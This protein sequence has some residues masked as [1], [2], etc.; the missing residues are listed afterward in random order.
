MIYK[1]AKVLSISL[2]FLSVQNLFS[3]TKIV[4]GTEAVKREFPFIVS[5]QKSSW[6]SYSHICGA[7]LV[8]PGWVLTAAHCVYRASA[9]SFRLK[10]GLH[11]QS[12]TTGVETIKA[13]KIIVHSS[14][15][16]AKSDYDYAL[17]KLAT[18]S[19]YAPIILNRDEISIPT[20]PTVSP[21]VTTA[22]WGATSEGGGVA[23]R[24]RKVTVPLVNQATCSKAYPNSIT[25]RMICAGNS[26]GGKDS[27]QGDSGGPLFI[28]ENNGERRLVGVVSWGEGCARPNKYGIYA[29]VNSA[30]S[31]I[32]KTIASN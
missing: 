24:L 14:Y 12:D 20:N 31:W 32:E 25:S 28:K 21:L 16:S 1:L 26:A 15:N 22:G 17:I 18:K 3:A 30:I 6:G 13:S 27:C 23:S 5:L 2:A 11:N 8:K 19:K 10:V 4:G 7:S 9:S 29:K